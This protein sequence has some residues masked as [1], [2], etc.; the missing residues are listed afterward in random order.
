[1]NQVDVTMVGATSDS[2]ISGNYK[3]RFEGVY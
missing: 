1:V 2:R 3:P